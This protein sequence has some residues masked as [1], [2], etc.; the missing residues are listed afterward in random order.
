MSSESYTDM[1][2]FVTTVVRYT[3]E[4][5][6][7]H[8]GPEPG[9]AADAEDK[10]IEA[11]ELERSV[12]AERRAAGEPRRPIL[13]HTFEY[14]LSGSEA[15]EESWPLPPCRPSPSG[16]IVAIT[17]VRTYLTRVT[18]AGSAIGGVEVHAEL[19]PSG[20]FCTAQLSDFGA[21]DLVVVQVEVALY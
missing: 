3:G 4:S 14:R 16:F 13:T 9:S 21:A 1:C 2:G 11:A 20:I 8:G 6:I 15:A 7:G 10:R 5:G 19:R 17:S 18:A 12:A